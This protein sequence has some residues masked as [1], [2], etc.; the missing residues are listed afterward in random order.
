MAIDGTTFDVADRPRNERA[1]V[2]PKSSRRRTAFTKIK[3]VSLLECGTRVLFGAVMGPYST[4]ENA[5]ASQVPPLLQHDMVC[6]A[7]R[8]FFFYT[9]ILLT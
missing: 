4:S 7:D 1:F 8:W 5:L 9:A 3:V 6:M 2:R